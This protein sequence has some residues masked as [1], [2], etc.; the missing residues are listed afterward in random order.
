[1]SK[2]LIIGSVIAIVAIFTFITLRDN[3]PSITNYPS[4][5]ETIVAFGDS[6]V[7]GL[8][9]S[10]GNDFVTLLSEMVGEP[11]V[12]LGRSGDTTEFALT[13]VGS[14]IE[15]NPKIVILLVGGN[16]FIQKIPEETTY[17][18]LSKI[19]QTIQDSGAIVVLLGVQEGLLRDQF[20]KE[21]KQLRDEYK[22]AYVSN[23]LE[24]LIGHSEFMY[25]SIHPNDKGHKVI[26]DRVYLVIKELLN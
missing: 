2:Q 10:R 6:L 9:T 20:K 3:S 15:Q 19:I 11:I 18:N 25:D 22:T 5:G 8:G 23:V 7:E 13:R 21:F 24:D 16:D 17:N 12:N 26:A 1:M 4:D 14:V